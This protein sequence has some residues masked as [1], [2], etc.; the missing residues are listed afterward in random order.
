MLGIRSATP[1]QGEAEQAWAA[2]IAA[3]QAALAAYFQLQATK[4]QSLAW[5]MA[6]NPVGQAAWIV[7][8]FHDWSDLR[9]KSFEEVYSLDRL[10][11]NVM[12][13]VMTDS[14]TTSVWYYRAVMEEFSAVLAPGVRVE[15]PTAFANFPGEP[16]YQPPPRSLGRTRATTSPAGPTS[17]AA[18]TS[19]PWRSRICTWRM[20]GPGPPHSRHAANERGGP[21]ARP[22]PRPNR[23]SRPFGACSAMWIIGLS[24]VAVKM[25]PNL[26]RRQ[27]DARLLVNMVSH[28]S[29]RATMRRKRGEDRAELEAWP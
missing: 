5:A 10:L 13:Y 23:R 4:P 29:K 25:E 6:D 11:T 3:N 15:V 24:P 26:S 22:T 27:S 28:C 9:A 21:S 16:L 1:P 14:F 20:C 17:P 7:E 8:R 18:A 12:I 2:R 19:P